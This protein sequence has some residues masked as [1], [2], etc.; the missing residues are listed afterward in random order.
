MKK[1]F[2]ATFLFLWGTLM[3][4]PS[5]THQLAAPIRQLY[6]FDQTQQLLKR[7]EAQGAVSIKTTTFGANASNAAWFPEERTIY[8]NVSKSRTQGSMICSIVFELHNA[9]SDNQ[10][11]KCDQLARTG[12]INKAQYIEAIERIEYNNALQA[13]RMLENG[14]RKGVFPSDSLWPIASTF[15]EHFRI[16]KM[17]GHSSVIG[18][19]YDDLIHV[20]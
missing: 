2:F 8:L 13:S 11:T 7:V 5:H 4:Y 14:V 3:A 17:A 9:L 18:Q 6:Q 12:K 20:Y 19:L 16:Q 10:F 1:I 15:E